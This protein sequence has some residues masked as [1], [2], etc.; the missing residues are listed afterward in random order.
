MSRKRPVIQEPPPP[1]AHR[2][3]SEAIVEA[4][5]GAAIELGP[6]ATL[7]SI[8]ER[9]G[10]G[11]ASLHR[12]FPSTAA[13]FAEVSRQTYR[14]LLQQVRELTSRSDLDPREM[15][16]AVCRVALAGPGLSLEHRRR[17]NTEIPLGWALPTV[18]PVY[19]EVLDELVRWAKAHLPDP[20]PDLEAR[21]F[22]AFGIVRGAVLLS[23]LFPAL[24]PPMETTLGIVSATVYRTLTGNQ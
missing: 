5:I 17:L 15:V 21:V 3:D 1:A 16:E 14:Q 11:T 9:A 18:E 4:V 19:R 20:P 7:A 10:V 6:Q 2:T 24:A 13:I 12:Y 8:A 23:L 22:V